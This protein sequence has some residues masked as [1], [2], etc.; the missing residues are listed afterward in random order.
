MTAPLHILTL[1]TLFPN[2][3]APNFGVFVARQTAALAARNGVRVTVIN[4]IGLPPFPLSRHPRY[5]D[6]RALERQDHWDGLTVHRPRFTLLP[7]LPERN[8]AA[9][10]RAVL[11]LVRRLHAERP[12][13]LGERRFQ[14]LAFIHRFILYETQRI[15][16]HP[17][18]L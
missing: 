6:L 11:P 12:F 7:G 3:A 8:P 17:N 9:I 5:R 16:C 14:C 1:A 18:H 13:D 2:S 15:L 10:A 4:P